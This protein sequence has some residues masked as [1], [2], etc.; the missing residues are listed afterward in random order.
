M[1]WTNTAKYQH[2]YP[3][4]T[5]ISDEKQQVNMII[6]QLKTLLDISMFAKKRQL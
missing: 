4:R 5:Y 6:I 1:K 2:K 3:K